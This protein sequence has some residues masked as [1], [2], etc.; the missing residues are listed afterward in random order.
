MQ[1]YIG[2]KQV[3]A[4]PQERDGQPGYKVVYS[5]GYTSW[6]PKET[7]EAAYFPIAAPDRISEQDVSA[8]AQMVGTQR[9]G[10]HAVVMVE[11]ANGF[12]VI[13]DSACVDA[14]NYD[15][16]LGCQLAGKKA[17]DRFW[18]HLGFVLAW[19]KNGLHR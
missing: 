11:G 1:N 15:H 17:A 18:S 8:F 16:E 9:A 3:A 4:E 7:F 5:D 13:E 12:S 2:V 19:A 10:N 6:S 14:E